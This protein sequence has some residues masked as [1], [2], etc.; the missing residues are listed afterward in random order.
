M[1]RYAPWLLRLFF[2]V[3]GIGLLV[4]GG[5][6]LVLALAGI[7]PPALTSTLLTT[8]VLHS[9]IHIAWALALLAAIIRRPPDRALAWWVIAFGASSIALGIVFILVDHPLGMPIEPSQN[10]FHFIDGPLGVLLGA[11]VLQT[12]RPIRAPA[13]ALGRITGA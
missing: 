6:S 7:T 12:A 11:W 2:W 1:D 4:Q 8:G 3:V 10:A 13:V 9:L 5:V